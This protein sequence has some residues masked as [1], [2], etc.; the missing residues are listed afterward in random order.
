M[1][2]MDRFRSANNLI[3]ISP[4]LPNRRGKRPVTIRGPLHVQCGDY[5]DDIAL[6]HLLDEVVA[7]AHIKAGPLPIGSANLLSLKVGGEVATADPFCT[8]GREHRSRRVRSPRASLPARER[9]RV[10]LLAGESFRELHH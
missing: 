5:G 1:S 8:S 4:S 9:G 6:R 7:W 3:T 2:Y 10:N